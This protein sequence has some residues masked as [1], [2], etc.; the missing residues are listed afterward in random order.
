[1]KSVGGR[2][3]VV[4][5]ALLALWLMPAGAAAKKGTVYVADERGGGIP[6]S[7]DNDCGAI[8]KIPPNGGPGTVLAA[9]DPGDALQNPSGLIPYGDKSL[10]AADYGSG[11]IVK[12]NRKSGA[13]HSF[14]TSPKFESPVD[15]A[16]K[17]GK[18]YVTDFDKD[19][20]FKVDLDTKSVH[21]VNS[22]PLAPDAAGVA[23]LG[24]RAFVSDWSA[25]VYTVNLN[26][27]AVHMLVKDDPLIDG[28][29]G[30]AV[31]PNHKSL[32]LAAWASNPNELFKVK[33]SN[34]DTHVVG[35]FDDIVAVT[36]RPAGG[37]LISDT[38]ND[39][40]DRVSQNGNSIT[41]FSDNPLY[42]YP[43]DIVIQ[44]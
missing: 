11:R 34:G 33:I 26:S 40:V 22:E 6:S 20:L 30:L 16:R 43:H 25:D 8:F 44:H 29:D 27:G 41:T 2:F 17:G 32:Y 38:E 39:E 42:D 7:C 13:T 12:I 23:V 28:S 14:V 18:L 5:G 36:L 24:K 15:L 4:L 10:L 31:A 35:G 19:A 21:K 1:M 9:G 37:F 3:L